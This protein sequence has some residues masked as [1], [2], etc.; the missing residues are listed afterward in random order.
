MLLPSIVT[1]MNK[2]KTTVHEQIQAY[3]DKQNHVNIAAS[4]G[5]MIT[6]A[7]KYRKQIAEVLQFS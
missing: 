4:D 5:K 1:S 6:C 3:R 7:S 2:Q